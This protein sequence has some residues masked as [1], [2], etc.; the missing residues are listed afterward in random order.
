[1][2][3]YYRNNRGVWEMSKED[4][5]RVTLDETSKEIFQLSNNPRTWLSWIVYLL[6][7]LEQHALDANP[8]YKDTYK[9]M[10]LA[11]QDA[12]KNR[13]RTGGW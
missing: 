6:G 13:L 5:V 4:E 12:I 11:L 8:V 3:L 9:E 10:L 2:M 1:M 7:R